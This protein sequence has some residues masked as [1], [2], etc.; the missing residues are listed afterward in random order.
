MVLI[1]SR[2]SLVLALFYLAAGVSSAAVEEPSFSAWKAKHGKSYVSAE[3]EAA[4]ATNFAASVARVAARNEL[5]ATGQSSWKAGL[6]QFSD[7]T[8]AEFLAAH[9]TPLTAE[10]QNCSATAATTK[11]P[12][13]HAIKEAP[14]PDKIDWRD[15]GAVSAVKNQGSCGS[16]WTFSTTGCL[17]SH[18]FLRNGK[19]NLLAEQQLVDCA[20]AFNNFGCDGGLPSQA[21]E[22]IHYNGGIDTEDSY[23]YVR[24]MPI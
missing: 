22:Y 6:N 14:I 4:A 19:M 18:N 21:F 5:F 15:A 2:S 9:T 10:G 3:L 20:G 1:I 24:R 13:E 23:N 12:L 11:L 8:P 7:L 16:C 17:E